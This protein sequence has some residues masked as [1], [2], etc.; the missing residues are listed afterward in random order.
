MQIKAF[1][2]IELLIT[3]AIIGILTAIAIP[4][5]QGYTKRAHYTEVVQATAP[6]KLG[7]EE[8]YQLNND[9][10]TCQAG[11]N[12]V[13]KNIDPGSGF[14]LVNSIIVDKDCKIVVTPKKLFGINP[15]DNYILNPV[16]EN[17]RLV[18]KSSGGG[19]DKGYAG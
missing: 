17:E 5:Y 14:G 15:E 11:K 10:A 8:C 4:S 12:G 3:M 7:I 19:V 2:L 18:W 9:L 6:F 16:T 1:T 13:P